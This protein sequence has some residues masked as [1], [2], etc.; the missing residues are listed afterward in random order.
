M[1][2]SSYTIHEVS[3]SGFNDPA[4]FTD[5]GNK[6]HVANAKGSQIGSPFERLSILRTS[7]VLRL[8]RV[9]HRTL[10]RIEE[11]LLRGLERINKA[12]VHLQIPTQTRDRAAYLLRKTLPHYTVFMS[13]VPLVV[14]VLV[15]AIREHQLPITED[16]VLEIV[17]TQS[18]HKNQLNRTKFFLMETLGIKWPSH[19]PECF[20]PQVI[21]AIQKNPTVLRR[22]KRKKGAL[23]YFN[24]L[25][26]LATRLLQSMTSM[27]YGGRFP[28]VLAASAVYT[29]DR[30]LLHVITQ[31]DAGE[32]IGAVD[33]SIRSHHNELWKFK[34][35]EIKKLLEV[36]E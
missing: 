30:L 11:R 31:T 8:K 33:Y 36:A 32:T 4:Q 26:R 7:K 19:R 20:I 18:R 25:E 29:I 3:E 17:P 14:C 34:S 1:V 27:D 16:D 13:Q 9:H 23:D 28:D 6:M 12:T 5:I 15:M 21:S 35:D 10:M 2:Q 24:R 22:L